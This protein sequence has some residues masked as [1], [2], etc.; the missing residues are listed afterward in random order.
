MCPC[1]R[2]VHVRAVACVGVRLLA[3]RG[4]HSG[5]LARKQ[6]VR[7]ETADMGAITAPAFK[8]LLQR[9]AQAFGRVDAVFA[10]AGFGEA[11]LVIDPDAS[12]NDVNDKDRCARAGSL[13]RSPH[14]NPLPRLFG[15][16]PRIPPP[17]SFASRHEPVMRVSCAYKVR[18]PLT[19]QST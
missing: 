18:W 12:R 16:P 8:E 7:Y 5:A 6:K 17:T 13:A 9:S 19:R 1:V 4:A 10:N 2:R 11:K 3:G 15:F 14:A